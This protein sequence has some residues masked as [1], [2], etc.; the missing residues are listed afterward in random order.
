MSVCQDYIRII[1]GVLSFQGFRVI[2]ELK[3]HDEAL[4]DKD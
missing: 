1:T 2:S 3:S 4:D